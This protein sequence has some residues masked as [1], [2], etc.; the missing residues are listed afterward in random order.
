MTPLVK[1]EGSAISHQP[2]AVLIHPS[3]NQ[4]GSKLVSSE[5]HFWANIA[6]KRFTSGLTTNTE[7]LIT[8]SNQFT[9]ILRRCLADSGQHEAK[10]PRSLTLAQCSLWHCI[11]HLTSRE[12]KQQSGPPASSIVIFNKLMKA[13]VVI[14]PK[15]VSKNNNYEAGNRLGHRLQIGPCW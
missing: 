1:S 12:D 14:R 5:W 7:V 13:L 10:Q 11:Y 15:V 2:S 8:S 4:L 3:Y 9:G 6:L